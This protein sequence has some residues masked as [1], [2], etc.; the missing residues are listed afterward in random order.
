[1]I[2]TEE[3]L[4]DSEYLRKLQYLR[5]DNIVTVKDDSHSALMMSLRLRS[6]TV[7]SLRLKLQTTHSQLERMR[8]EL[9]IEYTCHYVVSKRQIDDVDEK[10]RSVEQAF[11]RGLTMCFYP[12][13]M[14]ELH[15]CYVVL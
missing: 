3:I 7:S 11:L 2:S 15:F 5:G 13:T 12:A 1:M 14:T 10:K 8:P 6:H 4:T 9:T